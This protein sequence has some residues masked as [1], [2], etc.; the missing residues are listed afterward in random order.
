MKFV[1]N[2][3]KI[4]NKDLTYPGEGGA[5]VLHELTH[6]LAGQTLRTQMLWQNRKMSRYV[7]NAER[8][9]GTLAFPSGYYYIEDKPTNLLGIGMTRSG[10]GE[11]HITPAIEINSRAE[12][13][14][15]MVLADPKGEHYQA[16]YKL[17]RQRDYD[18]NVLSFQ[19]MDWSMS[20]NPLALAI[21]AAK[22]G[23][24]EKTQTYVNAVAEYHLSE[25]KRWR[26]G[27][28]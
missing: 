28:C 27:E 20:F 1:V 11:G 24:Y 5:P 10:K 4:P 25:T 12:L 18:V 9:L 8:I 2:T 14:P 3:K 16:S 15:S 19:N 17:M 21:A 26:E 6:D 22:K 7:T 13:Q 23:Y